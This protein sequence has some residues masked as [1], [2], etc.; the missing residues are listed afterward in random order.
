MQ[1]EY[2][3]MKKLSTC[4]FLILFSFSAP[5]FADDI[6][7]FQIEGMSIGDSL[8]DYFSEEEIKKSKK[9]YYKD[10]TF[11]AIELTSKIYKDY[12]EIQI[13]YKTIDKKYIIFSIDGLIDIE[14]LKD[15]IKQK[16]KIVSEI[17]ELF[18][19]LEKKVRDDWDM[20]SGHGKLHGVTFTFNSGDTADVVCYDYD[21]ETGYEDHLRVGVSRKEVIDWSYSNPF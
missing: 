11:T 17:S 1:T 10:K 15:C 20:V 21:V 13:H 6:R 5:S 16:S 12:D 19:N 8:L 14:N 18:K 9:D 4:L 2:S 3:N 7:D